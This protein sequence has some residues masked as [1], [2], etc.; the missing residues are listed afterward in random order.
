MSD[1]GLL[2]P[3][4]GFS[5][6]QIGGKQPG[7]VASYFLFPKSSFYLK[8]VRGSTHMVTGLDYGPNSGIFLSLGT[9][10]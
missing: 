9:G 10:T 1:W 2:V 3:K 6:L 7:F 4:S 5:D 8:T